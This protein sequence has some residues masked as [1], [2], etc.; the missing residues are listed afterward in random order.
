MLGGKKKKTVKCTRRADH[1]VGCFM[2][3]A[4]RLRGFD[5]E[6]MLKKALFSVKLLIS[7]VKHIMYCDL[8]VIRPAV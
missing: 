4:L 8:Y 2:I 5:H 3:K 6:A 7:K 1:T